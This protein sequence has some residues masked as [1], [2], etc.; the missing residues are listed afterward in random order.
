VLF[1]SRYFERLGP[2]QDWHDAV[3]DEGGSGGGADLATNWDTESS[4]EAR[5]G[6]RVEDTGEEGATE[7]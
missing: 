7:L 3:P 6:M 4:D 1:M 2:A 5:G